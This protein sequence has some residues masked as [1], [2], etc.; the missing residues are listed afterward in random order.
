MLRAIE[1]VELHRDPGD[2]H[3]PPTPYILSVA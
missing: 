1:Y 3:E 2:V